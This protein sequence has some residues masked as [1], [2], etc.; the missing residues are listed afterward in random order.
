LLLT[1]TLTRPLDSV[2]DIV[3]KAQKSFWQK[4]F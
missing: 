4:S 2:I 1:C 3:E